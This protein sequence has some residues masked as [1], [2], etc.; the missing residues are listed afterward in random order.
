MHA[1]QRIGMGSRRSAAPAPIEAGGSVSHEDVDVPSGAIVHLVGPCMRIGPIVRQRCIWCGA[2]IRDD[3]LSRIAFQIPEGKT[4]EQARA[5]GDFEPGHW[6]IGAWVAVDGVA[7]YVVRSRAEDEALG[8]DGQTP[9][10]A[11]CRLDPEAT[12]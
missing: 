2:L 12:K 4:E 11:C 5:D 10:G 9:D 6:E 1:M 8:A 7:R 3:D